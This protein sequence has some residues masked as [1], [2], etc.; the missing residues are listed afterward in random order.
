LYKPIPLNTM[1][2]AILF[3]LYSAGVGIAITLIGYF[4]GLDKTGASY[5]LGYLPLPFFILFLWM[6]MKERK[7]EDYGG[8]ISYGQCIGT[9]VLVGLFAG[10]AMGIF[11]Y[12]YSTAIN[13]GMMDMVMQKQ[14][15]A[16]RA[17]N[18]TADQIQKAQSYAK[19]FTS[20]AMMT[21]WTLGGD[22]VM[23]TIFSL[24]I[25]IFVKSKPGEG[26]VKSV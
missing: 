16:M 13:P 2:T 23:A 20:P 4:T 11:M 25:G 18:M 19:M 17:Q 5:W 12:L 14:A 6:A 26:E 1:V 21:A 24:I 7:Q 3:G 9:G 22:I 8:T 15:D 10:I